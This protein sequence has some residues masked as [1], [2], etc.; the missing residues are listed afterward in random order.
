VTLAQKTTFSIQSLTTAVTTWETLPAK[1]LITTQV[2]LHAHLKL[3]GVNHWDYN[4]FQV[5]HFINALLALFKIAR[6]VLQTHQIAQCVCMEQYL[7]LMLEITLLL[8]LLLNNT[9][10]QINMLWMEMVALVVL[11][12]HSLKV[13]LMVILQLIPAVHA[14]LI[15]CHVIC[16]SIVLHALV[17][18][19]WL[20]LLEDKLV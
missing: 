3:I 16:M 19:L 10:V 14:Q 17:L 8:A 1:P 7:L 5:P 11:L 6:I 2:A 9:I 18:L 20:M 15:A 13:L 12:V 4:W